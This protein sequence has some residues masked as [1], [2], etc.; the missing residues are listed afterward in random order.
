MLTPLLCKHSTEW[1]ICSHSPVSHCRVCLGVVMMAEHVHKPWWSPLTT[2]PTNM[3]LSLYTSCPGLAQ[4]AAPALTVWQLHGHKWWDR[5]REW[6]TRFFI[7]LLAK[8]WVLGYPNPWDRHTHSHCF[9]FLG[10]TPILKFHPVKTQ[11]SLQKL[12]GDKHDNQTCFFSSFDSRNKF[13][14]KITQTI[15][16]EDLEESLCTEIIHEPIIGGEHWW[17]FKKKQF[18]KKEPSK[19]PPKAC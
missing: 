12:L 16:K 15:I 19:S 7:Q 11:K 14:Q 5:Q 2:S 6:C 3:C 9:L 18:N 17:V 10:R 4:T 13:E 1:Q 8:C